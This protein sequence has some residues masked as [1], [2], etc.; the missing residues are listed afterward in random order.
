MEEWQECSL[1]S[2]LEKEKREWVFFHKNDDLRMKDDLF[3]LFYRTEGPWSPIKLLALG[4]Y[5]EDY[6]SISSR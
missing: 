4:K 6:G 5:Y 2:Y 3:N 1:F